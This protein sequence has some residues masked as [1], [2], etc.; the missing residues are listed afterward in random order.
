MTEE[1][2]KIRT[3]DLLTGAEIIALLKE[4]L[5]CMAGRRPRA[6]TRWISRD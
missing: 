3:D 4:H 2:W 5:D 1:Y 6:G